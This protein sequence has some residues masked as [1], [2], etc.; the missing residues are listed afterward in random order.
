MVCR[1]NYYLASGVVPKDFTY[2]QRKKFLATV[3]YYFW[4]DP[5][6]YKHCPDQII[7][8]CVPAEEQGNAYHW[9]QACDICQRVENQSRRRMKC[10]KKY[11]LVAVD[12]VSKWVEAI[13]SPTNK[14]SVVTSFLQGTI[15][16]RFGTPRAIINDE[17][18]HFINRVFAALLAKYSI[19]HRVATAYHPQTSGQ[20]EISNRELKRILEKTISSLRKDWSVK[21]RD[22]LWVYRTAFKTPIGMSPFQLVYG[23]ACHLPVELEHKAY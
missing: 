15:F 10:L 1:H 14:A 5:D 8:R 16:P 12:F 2:Q 20:I 22:A 13:A 9:C 17:G 4:D 11:I 23:K 19:T 7:R 3:K 18:T 6:L 21:L